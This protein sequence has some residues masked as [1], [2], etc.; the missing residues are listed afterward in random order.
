MPG[1]NEYAMIIKPAKYGDLRNYI[2]KFF[3]K[4]TWT[5]KIEILISLSEAL[6]SLHRMNLVH[7]D[8]HCKNIL[9]DENNKIFISDF[10]LC[11]HVDSK[12]GKWIIY[13]FIY[14]S[15]TTKFV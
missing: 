3:S 13:V 9:V 8:F 2:R 12:S 5:N 15:I 14:F 11:Q 10:G 7:R 6:N 1:E 4:L